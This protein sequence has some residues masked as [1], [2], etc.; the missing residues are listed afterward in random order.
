MSRLEPLFEFLFKYRPSLYSQGEIALLTPRLWIWLAAAVFLLLLPFV[1]RYR[2]VGGRVTRRDRWLLASLRL[3]ALGVL[4]LCLLQPAL[5]LSRVVAQESFVGL[6]VD[7]S[8]SMRIRD[9]GA[10]SR[11]EE[12]L[13]T[14]ATGPQGFVDSLQES[15]KVRYF[16]FGRASSRLASPSELTFADTESRI[17]GALEQAATELSDTPLAGLVLL[18]DGVD[19]ASEELSEALL[20]LRAAEVPVYTVGYGVERYEKDIELTQVVA[21]RTVLKGSSV[22]I[23]LTLQQ[24]GFSGR[25]AVLEVEDEGRIV[26]RREVRFPASGEAVKTEVGFTASEA[27][28]RL[29]RFRVVPEAQELIAENNERFALIEVEDSVKKV[30]YF[31]GEPRWEVKFMLRALQDDENVQLVL[32]QQTA[33]NKFLRLDVDEPGELQDGFPKTREEL[34]RYDG[35][36]LGSVEASAFTY[37]Q[38]KMIHDFVAQRGGG[39]LMIGG[40]RSFSEGGYQGTPVADVLPVR[41]G[42]PAGGEGDGEPFIVHANLSPYGRTHPALQLASDPET[43]QD[44]WASLPEVT[45]FNTITRLKPGATTLLEGEGWG[46]QTQVLL[47]HQR[48]GRGRALA[49]T[50]HDTWKWQ[51]QMP[52]EDKSHELFWQQLHRWLVSYVP[53]QVE[54]TT[55]KDRAAPGAPVVVEATV[56]DDRYLE[57]NSAQVQAEIR[58]PGG[59]VDYLP[60]EWTVERDGVFRGELWPTEDGFYQIEVTAEAD[61]KTLGTAETTFEVAAPTDEYFGAEKR[62]AF[63]E[64]LAQETGG[65]SYRPSELSRLAEDLSYSRDGATVLEFRDLW[66]MPALFLLLTLLLS[67]EWFYRRLRGLP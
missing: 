62:K 30:L 19:T 58:L 1:W 9:E 24:R 54:V 40:R 66:D 67:S 45:V 59:D 64:N 41:L 27:G 4:F 3:L 2:L 49:L 47:A 6:V 28:A 25:S 5:Q 38:M 8:Q 32:L 29:F 61:G 33:T 13:T 53:S 63:L 18:S 31:E 65:R 55:D 46:G 7:D 23:E 17:G 37:D 39:F 57:V 35:L 42:A 44:L 12:L 50:P 43:S 48:F 22:E 10:S 11:G 21:P 26:N 20:L 60:L 51:M 52:L 15:F 34:F 56:R 16:G 14:L 36:V